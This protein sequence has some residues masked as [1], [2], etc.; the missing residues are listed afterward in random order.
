M[1]VTK[2]NSNETYTCSSYEEASYA[3]NKI[4]SRD[5]TKYTTNNNLNGKTNFKQ[6]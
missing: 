3:I 1:K 2:K 6:S 5:F 4:N